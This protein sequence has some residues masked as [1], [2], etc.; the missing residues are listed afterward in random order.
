MFVWADR[1]KGRVKANS[2]FT[3]INDEGYLTYS[4]FSLPLRASR[5]ERAKEHE[6]QGGDNR[7]TMDTPP[8]CRVVLLV[9]L[10]IQ[11]ALMVVSGRPRGKLKNA[12]P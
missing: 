10:I 6:K 12:V 4:F 7:M 3:D 8:L 5:E 2:Y 1:C 11:Y 9:A